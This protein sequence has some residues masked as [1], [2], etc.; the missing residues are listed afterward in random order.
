LVFKAKLKHLIV[1]IKNLHVRIF[2]FHSIE[3]YYFSE[4]P[5]PVDAIDHLRTHTIEINFISASQMNT[6]YLLIEGEFK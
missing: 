3:I 2:R 4:Q 5:T 6:R 1:Q